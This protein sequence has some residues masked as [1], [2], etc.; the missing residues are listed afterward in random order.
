MSA[1]V[2]ILS[3]QSERRTYFEIRVALH[4]TWNAKKVLRFAQDDC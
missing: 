4:A 1:R 2:V 3:E